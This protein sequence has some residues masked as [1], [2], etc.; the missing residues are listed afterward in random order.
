[1]PLG[2]TTRSPVLAALGYPSMSGMAFPCN[3]NPFLGEATQ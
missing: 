2:V 3:L 1:M